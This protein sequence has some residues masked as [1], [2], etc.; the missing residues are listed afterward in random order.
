[1][2]TQASIG[3]DGAFVCHAIPGS[4]SSRRT[5]TSE[6]LRSKEFEMG[7]R[8]EVLTGWTIVALIASWVAPLQAQS[9]GSVVTVEGGSVRGAI[10]S[11][12]LA[13]KGIPYAASPVR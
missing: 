11:D 13:F 12:V 3:I 6:R 4:R 9:D 10:A 1:M 8:M 7:R 5:R 2:K